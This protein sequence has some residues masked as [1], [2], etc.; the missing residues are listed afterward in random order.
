MPQQELADELFA[1][2]RDR[3]PV[4]PLTEREPALSVEDAYA[5]AGINV[6]RHLAA[7]SVL[8]G[9]KVGLTSKA[10]QEQLGVGEPDF[11]ALLSHMFVEEGA[12]VDLGVLVQPRVEGEIAFV[13]GD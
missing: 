11:G 12:D 1:A 9:R 7:G 6:E 4:A 2:E 13:M 3:V 10:M 8:Q 5:I